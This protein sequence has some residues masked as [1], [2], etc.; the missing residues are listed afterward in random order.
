M[1]AVTVGSNVASG[2]SS[3][4]ERR[5]QNAIE[6]VA[7]DGIVN[8]PEARELVKQ[9]MGSKDEF[10]FTYGL[11]NVLRELYSAYTIIDLPEDARL[12]R[13]AFEILK[14][15]ASFQNW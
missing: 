11:N 8:A 15:Y 6:L 2:W 5:V 9:F 7:A 1:S 4:S 14:P 3:Q 10:M 13:D 12:T